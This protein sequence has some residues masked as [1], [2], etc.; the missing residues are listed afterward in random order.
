[1]TSDAS[2]LAKFGQYNQETYRLNASYNAFDFF[3]LHFH[4]ELSAF[5]GQLLFDQAE[6]VNEC[7][8]CALPWLAVFM[9]FTGISYVL[10]LYERKKAS[11]SSVPKKVI[12]LGHS[13]GGVVSM[14]G[15]CFPW[16]S[17]I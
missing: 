3:A 9:K 7:I 6:Y 12:L 5:S 16:L 17:A 1:M 8:R 14:Y 15:H 4:E 11:L 10:G 2:V 13:M